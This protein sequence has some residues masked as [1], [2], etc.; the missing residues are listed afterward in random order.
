[1]G[2]QVRACTRVATM[3][4]LAAVSCLAA[5][6]LRLLDAVKRRDQKTVESLVRERAGLN[7]TQPDGATA[8][9]WAAYLDDQKTAELLLSAGAEVNTADE[10]GETPLTLACANGNAS[11][12]D[13]LLRA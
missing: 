10:Y 3:T 9:A 2:M 4:L 12:V 1:M 6:D 11:L 13:K 5:N 7:A 8:L